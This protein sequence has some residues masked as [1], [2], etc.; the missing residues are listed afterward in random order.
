M[1]N[2]VK[3]F[4]L[5]IILALSACATPNPGYTYLLTPV[6]SPGVADAQ[7]T[8]Y[9]AVE[10]ATRSAA[11]PTQTAQ[12]INAI[13]TGQASIATSQ[14]G[15]T[16]DAIAIQIT[17]QAISLE[18]TRQAQAM[19]ST[20]TFQAISAAGTS[21]A[22]GGLATAE[23]YLIADEARRLSLQRE[24]EAATIERQRA[25][26]KALPWLIGVVSLACLTVAGS[27]AYTF[28]KRSQPEIVRDNDNQPRLIIYGGGVQAL[29]NP[30]RPLLSAPVAPPV[31]PDNDMTP[32]VLPTLKTGHVLIAG[33]TGA[34]KSTAMQAVLSHRQNV[35]VLDPHDTPGTCGNNATVI[36]GGRNFE[37]ISEF[38]GQTRTLLNDRYQ[39]RARGVARFDPITVATDE[40]PAIVTALGREIGD[41]WREWLREGRKVGLFFV[42]STQSTRVQTLGIKGEGD[43]LENFT[44]VLALGKVATSD[45]PDL[46]QGMEWPAVIRTAQGARPVIIPHNEND[47]APSIVEL[48]R[49]QGLIDQP[50]QSFTA[51]TPKPIETEKWGTITP[52]EIMNVLRMKRAGES[53]RAIERAVF[54]HEAGAAYHKVKAVMK[55][56]GN[57]LQTV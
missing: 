56:Y 54:G 45:Y 17:S 30:A 13:A 57:M 2:T 43:L 44:Y 18:G 9:A 55:T 25:W 6:A 12:A 37:A 10:G 28:V 35:V 47:N 24:A 7:A 29:A 5:F 42:V 51:P 38:I 32:V 14:A 1:T 39:Q 8:Y 34:G 36:G 31:P 27:L 40:M 20:A 22:V 26:N 11:Y 52:L 23:A 4:S 46:V 49:Q 19:I 48:P 16:S 50:S 33:E 15:A 3:I 41:V 21:Q 53:G